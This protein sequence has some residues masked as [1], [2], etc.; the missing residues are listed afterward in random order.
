MD[1]NKKNAPKALPEFLIPQPQNL[2]K[3]RPEFLKPP[4]P[5]KELTEE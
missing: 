4:Q 2:P 1:S 5:G 3:A